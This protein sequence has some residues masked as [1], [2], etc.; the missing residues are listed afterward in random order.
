M[1]QNINAISCPEKLF[2]FLSGSGENPFREKS[3]YNYDLENI[4]S[5]KTTNSHLTTVLLKH[6]I[7]NFNTLQTLLIKRDVLFSIARV[8]IK[9][10]R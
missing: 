9:T 4:I 2:V 10:L 8:V 5:I 6:L 3:D 7:N 1:H